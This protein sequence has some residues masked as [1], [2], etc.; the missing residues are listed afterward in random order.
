MNKN[1]FSQTGAGETFSYNGYT[2]TDNNET[3]KGYKYNSIPITFN[4][5]SPEDTIS[6]EDRVKFYKKVFKTKNP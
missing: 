4:D 3:E 6:K 5:P 2:S 1:Y